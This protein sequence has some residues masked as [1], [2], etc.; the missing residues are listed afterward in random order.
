MRGALGAWAIVVVVLALA[1]LLGPVASSSYL[2]LL[3]NVMLMFMTL[4]LSWDVVARTGQLSLAHAGFFG[5][6]AY[7]V[8][9]GYRLAA[10]PPLLGMLL[11]AGVAGLVALVLGVATLRLRG[12]YFAI[13]TLAFGEVLRTLALELPDLTGGPVGISMPPLFGGNRVQS[14]YLAGL[15]LL[16]ALALSLG[17]RYS[18]LHYAASAIRVN[19]RVAA[20]MGVDVVRVKVAL[21]VASAVLAALAGAFYMPF[22]THTDPYDAFS[23][24]RSVTPLVFSIFGGLYTTAGPIVGTL[25]LRSLEEYLRV[26]PPWKEGYLVAYGAILVVAVLF[27]SRGLVGVVQTRLQPWLVWRP[28]FSK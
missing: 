11:A 28:R 22:I 9:L 21:F 7:T 16:V 3:A 17:I 8:A 25:L 26:T 20:V 18:P 27:L 6:G 5:I 13:A 14:Y 19:E 10:L 4:A 12:I 1:P 2:L 23:V 15:L 24:E